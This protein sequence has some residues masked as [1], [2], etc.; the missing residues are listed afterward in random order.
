MKIEKYHAATATP[1]APDPDRRDTRDP[2][3]VH[4]LRL[5]LH[6]GHVERRALRVVEDELV[7]ASEPVDVVEELAGRR[8]A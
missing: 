2:T 7:P 5:L 3:S 8:P 4:G 1:M 6:A